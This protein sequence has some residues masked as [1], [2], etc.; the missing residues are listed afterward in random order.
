MTAGMMPHT[1]VPTPPSG[2]EEE[3]NVSSPT[4]LDTEEYHAR[5]NEY[6][7]EIHEKA[8]AM[9]EDRNDVDVEYSVRIA[10]PSGRH[11]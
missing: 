8:E 9:Q 5:A 2:A 6:M 1:D 3:R 10:Q 11:Q 7:D 4:E